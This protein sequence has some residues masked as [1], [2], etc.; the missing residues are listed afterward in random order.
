MILEEICSIYMYFL[1]SFGLDLL[2]SL[3]EL[4]ACSAI[5]RQC[6]LNEWAND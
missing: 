2:V 5:E 6:M 4:W 1:R 3:V